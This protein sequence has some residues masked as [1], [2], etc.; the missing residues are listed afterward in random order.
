MFDREREGEAAVSMHGSQA[1]TEC[2]WAPG[3]LVGMSVKE[4]VCFPSV[5]RFMNVFAIR[6]A[7][8]VGAVAQSR[9]VCHSLFFF[10]D[11]LHV[12]LLYLAVLLVLISGLC[13]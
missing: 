1:A 10:A 2:L 12:V 11:I 5:S 9:F 4:R 8:F 7:I 6:G 13:I 3:L